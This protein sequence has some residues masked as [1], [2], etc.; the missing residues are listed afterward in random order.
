MIYKLTESIE[1]I[2]GFETKRPRYESTHIVERIHYYV[3]ISEYR[4]KHPPI[5]CVAVK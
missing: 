2:I 3:S 5:M 4:L 1:Q